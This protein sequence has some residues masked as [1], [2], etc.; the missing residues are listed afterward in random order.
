MLNDLKSISDG[1]FCCKLN[2]S[3]QGGGEGG[4]SKISWTLRSTG[5]GMVISN[6]VR[7]YYTSF[8]LYLYHVYHSSPLFRLRSCFDKHTQHQKHL[9]RT[10][11][12]INLQLFYIYST[13]LKCSVGKRL[14][15]LLWFQEIDKWTLWMTIF[16]ISS[17]YQRAPGTEKVW[18]RTTLWGT[19]SISSSPT[20]IFGLME[21]RWDHSSD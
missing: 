1:I 11:S 13:K 21:C 7:W 14:F 4:N 5:A 15:S 16:D 19:A 10:N 17:I 18:R 9:W 6:H 12:A 20:Q 8:C 3:L 2:V